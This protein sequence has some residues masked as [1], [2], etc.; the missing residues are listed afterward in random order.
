MSFAN[1]YR[2]IKLTTPELMRVFPSAKSHCIR[3][4]VRSKPGLGLLVSDV[5]LVH[6]VVRGVID[7]GDC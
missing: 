2:N 1:F 3:Y 6:I 5:A 4:V 7:D